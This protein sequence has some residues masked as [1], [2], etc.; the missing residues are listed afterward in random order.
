MNASKSSVVRRVKA[1]VFASFA[2]VLMGMGTW[3]CVGEG[4]LEETPCPN[5][6]VFVNSVSP[7]IE[8]RCGTLDCHGQP[9]RN[10]R[11]Y[12]RLGL[13]HPAEM[14]V[15]GGAPTTTVELESNFAAVCNLEPEAMQAL[16]KSGGASAEK[17]LLV[18]KARGEERHKGGKV[19]NT[20]DDG[21][22]CIVNWLMGAGPMI[23]GPDCQAAVTQLQ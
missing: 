8:R 1:L 13:R 9:T 6:D 22:L 19:V 10:M 5:H 17:L 16:Q 15:A 14:N 3:A 20:N 18:L 12:G 2:L 4:E 23:V 21:D 7:Y 11:I